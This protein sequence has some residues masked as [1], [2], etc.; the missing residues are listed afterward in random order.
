LRVTSI[1]VSCVYADTLSTGQ[2]PPTNGSHGSQLDTQASNGPSTFEQAGNHFGFTHEE[3]QKLAFGFSL[4]ASASRK[5]TPIG[6]PIPQARY[7]VSHSYPQQING[8]REDTDI[9][10][11]SMEPHTSLQLGGSPSLPIVSTA[12]LPLP[13]RHRK[14]VPHQRTTGNQATALLPGRVEPLTEPDLLAF[15]NRQNGMFHCLVPV[16]GEFCGYVNKKK[17]RMLSHIRD[18]HLDQR[19]WHCGGQCGTRGW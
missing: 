7:A 12:S 4:V 19:P 6:G 14:D 3:A 15:S 2:P 9:P 5:L 11:R 16:E 10:A 1:L 13:T 8:N 17:N 18:K